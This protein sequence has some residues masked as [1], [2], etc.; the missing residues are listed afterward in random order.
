MHML[1]TAAVGNTQGRTSI[2]AGYPHK[3]DSPNYSSGSDSPP[4]PPGMSPSPDYAELARNFGNFSRPTPKLGPLT[5]VEG[6]AVLPTSQLQC[7]HSCCNEVHAELV[8]ACAH[9]TSHPHSCN[10][11]TFHGNP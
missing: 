8:M 3:Y 11:T 4:S 9:D 5:L 10:I 6:N 1:A 7:S 2:A